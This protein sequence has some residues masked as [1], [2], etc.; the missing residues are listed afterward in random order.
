MGQRSRNCSGLM[1]KTRAGPGGP[2]STEKSLYR[3]Q[4]KSSGWWCRQS[5]L[6]SHR[7]V[8]S[9]SHLGAVLNSGWPAE[10][11]CTAFTLVPAAQQRCACCAADHACNWCCWQYNGILRKHTPK[12]RAAAKD[13][14]RWR[15]PSEVSWG[16]QGQRWAGNVPAS[17]GFVCAAPAPET[18]RVQTFFACHCQPC[19][20][21]GDMFRLDQLLRS[22]GVAQSRTCPDGVL[23]D[24][25]LK[26]RTTV[27]LRM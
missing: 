23:A 26:T 6:A 8:G 1:N 15:D 22:P 20:K 10:P 27:A 12:W 3:H 7:V 13:E 16:P 9:C 4:W 17:G 19:Q 18:W 2:I 25:H 5:Y 14:R 21:D 11:N 24:K